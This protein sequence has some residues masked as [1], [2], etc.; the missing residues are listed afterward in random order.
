VRRRYGALKVCILGVATALMAG[1]AL[2]Q[3]TSDPLPRR[4]Y[5]GVS[6]EQTPSGVKV[7]SVAAGSTA[8]AAGM[9]AGDMVLG[10]DDRATPTTA[11][12]VGSLGGHR[13]GDAVSIRIQRNADIRTVTVTLKPYPQEQMPNAAISYG[14]VESPVGVRL[15]TIISIPQTPLQ[16]RYPA[17]LFIQ[18][19][20]CGSIDTP[21]G[22]PVGTTALVAAVGSRGFVTMR[23]EK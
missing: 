5:F 4:G 7:T 11:A 18:G 6:L 17:A 9:T 12:V 23:V 20:G 10:I 22:P 1:N 15:R 19:G 2:A 14:S 3:S 16:E 8:A 13:G 21:I